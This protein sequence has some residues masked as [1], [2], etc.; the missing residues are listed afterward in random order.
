MSHVCLPSLT[1]LSMTSDNINSELIHKNHPNLQKLTLS[2]T[3]H[4]TWHS[5]LVFEN[6]IA[7][8]ITISHFQFISDFLPGFAETF[9]I[10]QELYLDFDCLVPKEIHVEHPRLQKL[11]MKHRHDI[12]RL[13]IV[14]ARLNQLMLDVSC[15]IDQLRIQ[16]P[17]LYLLDVHNI[18]LLSAIALAAPKLDI[19]KFHKDMPP[20]QAIQS[21][22]TLT[23]RA[24]QWQKSYEKGL[25]YLNVLRLVEVVAENPLDFSIPQLKILKL[26]RCLF[27]NLTIKIPKLQILKI[28]HC[29]FV[30][31]KFSMACPQLSQLTF[32]YSTKNWTP[33]WES[34]FAAMEDGFLEDLDLS[35]AK[36][37]T[38]PFSKIGNRFCKL[39][40]LVLSR[41]P[42][43]TESILSAF[44][45]VSP[46]LEELVMIEP[47]EC[48]QKAV[49]ES[50]TLI[51][52]E[53][54]QSVGLSEISISCPKLMC[55]FSLAH[56]K[57]L[58]SVQLNVPMLTHL[59]LYECPEITDQMFQSVQSQMPQCKVLYLAMCSK[60]CHVK[61][62]I[63]TL[64]VVGITGCD[65]L[66][67][68]QGSLTTPQ[69]IKVQLCP[70][71]YSLKQLKYEKLT[72]L[73]LFNNSSIG[74]NGLPSLQGV[75]HL[76]ISDCSSLYN[77]NFSSNTLENLHVSFCEHIQNPGLKCP[78]IRC[79]YFVSMRE[80]NKEAVKAK[81]AELPNVTITD[82]SIEGE[83]H[84]LRFTRSTTRCLVM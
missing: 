76:F 69:S 54:P 36:L 50:P 56:A 79:I 60:I 67:T 59:E 43:L 35:G 26:R 77:P 34:I 20:V 41:C 27:S 3:H 57:R 63:P 55:G 65:S 78:V 70:K 1:E 7:L 74:D 48:F 17:D 38:I 28:K 44:L 83:D 32:A 25:P 30:E 4:F 19:A 37:Q 68:I 53:W 45:K 52:L 71:L 73:K 42:D 22:R 10:L 24:I 33:D 18:G 84:P 21:V 2:S 81:I 16:C 6:L 8:S 23:L 15:R 72:S 46:S 14:C 80:F 11:T 40:K 9:P 47:P 64:E 62:I 12:G 29:S 75:T 39:R 58:R 51:K 82:I 31:V 13:S 49:I 5:G 66:Q 61:L